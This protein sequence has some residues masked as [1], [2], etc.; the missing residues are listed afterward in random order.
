VL[1]PSLPGRGAAGP[2]AHFA[3]ARYGVHDIE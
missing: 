2:L 3:A 1:F